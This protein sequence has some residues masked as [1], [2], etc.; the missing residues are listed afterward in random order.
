MSLTWASCAAEIVT[1]S[2]VS[3]LASTSIHPPSETVPSV[4]RRCPDPVGALYLPSVPLG[5]GITRALRSTATRNGPR[6]L[7]AVPQYLLDL[8]FLSSSSTLAAS[9]HRILTDLGYLVIGRTP[10]N[11]IAASHT[12][13]PPF[14]STIFLPLH[15]RACRWK[16]KALA[17]KG[18]T[19][20]SG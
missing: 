14:S 1:R 2:Q 17:R 16:V 19:S 13:T 15:T 11:A 20:C 18:S 9:Y 6:R 8:N 7:S 12:Y 3:I 5:S 4:R 10:R